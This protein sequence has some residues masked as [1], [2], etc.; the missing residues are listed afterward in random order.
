MN[1]QNVFNINF[2]GKVEDK[3][4]SNTRPYLTPQKPDTFE[5][6]TAP[7][8]EAKKDTVLGKIANMYNKMVPLKLDPE[9]T[10][11]MKKDN[12]DASNV[13]SLFKEMTMSD[14]K[15]ITLR[16]CAY[17]K[18]NNYVMEAL[19]KNGTTLRLL[20]KNLNTL[21]QESIQFEYDDKGNA[22]SKKVMTNDFRTNTFNESK[23]TFSKEG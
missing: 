23:F 20:D 12:L 11:I 1:I 19:H 5:R 16:R 14:T 10:E 9:S 22:I 21:E 13:L 4:T 2:A 17:D 6:T 18:E 7:K 3:K 8:T 15:K